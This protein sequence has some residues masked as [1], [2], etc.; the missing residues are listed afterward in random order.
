[1]HVKLRRRRWLFYAIQE[2]ARVFSFS[3]NRGG[4][5]GPKPKCQQ[6]IIISMNFINFSCLTFKLF[7]SRRRGE[8]SGVVF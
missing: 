7:C 4:G 5:G 6:R 3:H 1:M 8:V 2:L